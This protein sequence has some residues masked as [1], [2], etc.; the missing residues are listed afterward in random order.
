MA[1]VLFVTHPEVVVDPATPVPAW[2]LS[3]QGVRRMRAFA[4]SPEAEGLTAI[5]SSNETKAMQAAD[6]LAERVGVAVGRLHALHENDRGA[7]GFLPPPEFEVVADAFFAEPE[8][9]V[10]GWERAIDA[11]DRIVAAFDQVLAAS[12]A[13]KIA[14]VSHGA[15]GTLL[16]CRLFD[17]PISRAADQ[18]F[19]G[20]YWTWDTVARQVLHGWRPIAPC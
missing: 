7:T 12:P 1:L 11:Q 20:H 17:K 14:I 3:E 19:Q 8:R 9:S 2:G 6:I 10:R 18:P 15:V 13:G 4:A 16:L 5:W